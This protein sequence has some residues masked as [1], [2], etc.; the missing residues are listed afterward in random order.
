M[1]G[2]INIIA[3]VRALII[4]P[5][6]GLIYQPTHQEILFQEGLSFFD[7]NDY[8]LKDNLGLSINKSAEAPIVK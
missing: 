5:L 8:E 3:H 1:H 2:L 6:G 7:L 4:K